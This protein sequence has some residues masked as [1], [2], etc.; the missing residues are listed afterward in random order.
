MTEELFRDD[1]YLTR[2]EASVVSAGEAGIVLDRTVFYPESGGQP[3]DTGILRKAD[4]TEIRI[5]DTRKD[6]TTG[7]PLHIPADDQPALAPGD[8]VTCEIDW[9]RRFRHMRMH[10]ALHLICAL[11]D[12]EITGAQVGMEKSR[13][14]LNKPDGLDKETLQTAFDA[15][16]AADHPVGASWISDEELDSRPELVRTMSVKPPTGMGRVRLVG[17]GDGEID[18]QPCGGTHVSRTGELGAMRIGKI[19]NK[20]KANRRVNIHFAD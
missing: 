14:D 18:L 3:G 6:K 10:T 2:C 19:E 1:S 13:I 5:A 8:A 16:V 12:A 20:G 15:V 17:I 4:G 11:V 9:E 7:G